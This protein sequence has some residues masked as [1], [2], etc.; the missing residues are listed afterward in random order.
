MSD[1]GEKWVV[2]QV[3]EGAN[4]YVDVVD[5][6]GAVVCVVAAGVG[7]KEL[8]YAR[9]IA[10]CVNALRGLTTER[11][12]SMA[13]VPRP[14]WWLPVYEGQARAEDGAKQD[15]CVSPAMAALLVPFFESRPCMTRQ[16][17]M[18]Q[19][20]EALNAE[21]VRLGLTQEDMAD[22]LGVDESTFSRWERG[23]RML[24]LYDWAMLESLFAEQGKRLAAELPT[25]S[26]GPRV[27]R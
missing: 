23:Q 1:F 3:V 7:S 13:Q 9:R 20:G 5:A 10:A 2:L 25:P 24:S 21:R 16:Q 18:R 22:A 6:A 15:L 11:I 26:G 8:E 4:A 12:E 19:A 14:S 27:C 17:F